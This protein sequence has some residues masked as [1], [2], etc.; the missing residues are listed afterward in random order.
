MVSGKHCSKEIKTGADTAGWKN[1]LLLHGIDVQKWAVA[2]L[3]WR[4]GKP[5]PLVQLAIP[6]AAVLQ[7]GHV[8]LLILWQPLWELVLVIV[9][10]VWVAHRMQDLDCCSLGRPRVDDTDGSASSVVLVLQ[11]WIS[12]TSLA[13][14]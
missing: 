10:Q 6:T 13:V 7:Q 3:A 12:K 9:T 14:L 11:H 1:S 2:G 5:N 8:R 4:G